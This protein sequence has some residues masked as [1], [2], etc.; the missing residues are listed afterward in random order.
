MT[1]QVAELA[2]ILK[3]AIEVEEN[4]L[5]T[6]TKFADQTQ[7]ENGKRMFLRLAQDER[8]HRAILEKQL[9]GLP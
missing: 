9:K 3:T 8:E 1:P 2:K 6:F 5:A 4:G 7:D